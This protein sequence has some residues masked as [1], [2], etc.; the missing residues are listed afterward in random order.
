MENV[1]L[2]KKT[3]PKNREWEYSVVKC[4]GEAI[5]YIDLEVKQCK[6]FRRV[7]VVFEHSTDGD[8]FYQEG[9]SVKDCECSVVD[10]YGDLV[11]DFDCPHPLVNRVARRA[12]S[13]TGVYMVTIETMGYLRIKVRGYGNMATTKLG[14]SI[15][16]EK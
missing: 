11:A 5:V 3:Q 16:Y 7:E 14:I 6:H 4:R 2:R 12:L 13:A 10:E 1:K 9:F 15:A 8:D